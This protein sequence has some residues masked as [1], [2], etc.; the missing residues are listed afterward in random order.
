LRPDDQ[1]VR[2]EHDLQPHLVER[3][4]LERELG[5]AG[6]LVVADPVF[7]PGA[8]AMAALD[9]RDVGVGLVGQDR[10]EAIPV[11]VGERQLRAGVGALPPHDHPQ[12]LRPSAEAEPVD[13]LHDLAVGALAVVPI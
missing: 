9:D 2:Q 12:P 10:L 13:D 8:L 4:L 11:A 6:V 1:V 3:E 7:N 5:Q